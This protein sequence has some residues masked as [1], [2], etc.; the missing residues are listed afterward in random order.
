MALY[1]ACHTCDE[2]KVSIPP[3]AVAPVQPATSRRKCE[4][5]GEGNQQTRVSRFY[6]TP[7]LSFFQPC[8]RPLLSGM[9]LYGDLPQARNASASSSD[10]PSWATN[11]PQ[12]SFRKP[13]LLAPPS[14]L[15]RAGRGAGR[16]AATP[17]RG[18]PRTDVSLPPTSASAFNIFSVA[19]PMQDEYDPTRPNDYE[20]II[21]ER[22][23]RKQEA[24]QEEER[25]ARKR[26]Q[27]R[28]QE[29][30]TTPWVSTC[31]CL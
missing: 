25:Q 16:G 4:P 9:S 30:Q 27:L 15:L 28:E 17:G 24:Q 29:V 22:E 26:E 31:R 21:R 1:F 2:I 23:Q 14:A 5:G 18:P 12:P 6:D 11:K 10:A 3:R 19:G 7:R 8:P 20:D 13:T